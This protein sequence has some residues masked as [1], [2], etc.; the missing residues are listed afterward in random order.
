L[1]VVRQQIAHSEPSPTLLSVV[2]VLVRR[3]G[4]YVREHSDYL[5]PH[6]ISSYA[7]SSAIQLSH[8]ALVMLGMFSWVAG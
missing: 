3:P 7:V 6:I 1:V 8:T 5:V 4:R 2:M